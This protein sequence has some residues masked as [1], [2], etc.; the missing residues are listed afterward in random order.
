[1]SDT[2]LAKFGKIRSFLWPVHSHENRKLIPMLLIAFLT[3][4]N[5][6]ILRTAKDALVVTARGSGA[7]AIPFIKV[8]VL[9]PM[10]FFLTYL[11]AKMSNKL[12]REQVFYSMVSLFLGFFALFILVLYPAKDLLHPH[13]TA[14]YLE[15]IFPAGL[16]G[17]IAIFR[18]WTF[19]CYYVMSELWGNIVLSML[20]WGFANEVTKVK[21]ASRFYGLIGIALNFAGIAAGQISIA[22]SSPVFNL[23]LP[24]GHD[25][26]EQTLILLV[27][28]VIISGLITMGIFRWMMVNDI[29]K[30][31]A[32]HKKSPKKKFKMSLRETFSYLANSRY[33][34]NIALVVLTYNL[35]INLVEVLWKGELKLL[36]PTPND[37]NIHMSYVSTAMG[38]V[39]TFLSLCVVGKSLEKFGWGFTAAITPVVLLITSIGFFGLLMSKIYAYE[40]TYALLGMSPL[41]LV[42]IFGS[43]HNAFCRG[44][45]YSVFD[46]TKEIAFIPLSLESKVKG[47]A[48]IDGVGS[49]LGKSGGSL[50]HQSLLMVFAN[51]LT[52][53]A[54]YVAVIVILAIVVWIIAVKNL[55]KEFEKINESHS[56]PIDTEEKSSQSKAPVITTLST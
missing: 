18:N 2:D 32:E 30:L 4:F 55:G 13:Q 9:L 12:N 7:E 3:S 16:K 6:N 37:Y 20:F 43:A 8:W 17:L 45:K 29:F 23:S 11:F 26:W 28:T 22:F 51:S 10:A 1:M 5:Y 34:L 48:A 15:T 35:V 40:A 56:E 44:S 38:I 36:Y 54:P 47:K 53:S 46:S 21:E 50:I 41:Y 31:Q 52:S 27:T 39:A 19:T 42:C 24:F 25:A 14:D 33:L 49:R